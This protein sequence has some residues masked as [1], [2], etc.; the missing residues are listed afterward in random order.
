MDPISYSDSYLFGYFLSEEHG[1]FSGNVMPIC[2]S[3]LI[4]FW[5]LEKHRVFSQVFGYIVKNFSEKKVK[6]A[7]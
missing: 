3:I 1:Y 4:W 5:I 6:K 2:L 7:C